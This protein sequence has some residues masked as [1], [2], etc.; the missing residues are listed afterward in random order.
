MAMG[1][2]TQQISDEMN[3]ILTEASTYGH[4]VD[5]ARSRAQRMLEM[6]QKL[7]QSTDVD[8]EALPTTLQDIQGAASKMQALAKRLEIVRALA[9]VK[10]NEANFL[11]SH[12][13]KQGSHE[14]E[15]R[16]YG[17]EAFYLN[18]ILRQGL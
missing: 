3:Q 14:F 7:E 15:A 2:T 12:N 18:E 1:L 5:S 13:G 17:H 4:T 10:A 8:Q 6:A 16:R 11:A 9:I